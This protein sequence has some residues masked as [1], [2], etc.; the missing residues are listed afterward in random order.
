MPKTKI[1]LKRGRREI[2]CGG[3]THRCGGPTKNSR[4]P[5]RRSE[6]LRRD[7]LVAVAEEAVCDDFFGDAGRQAL[8]PVAAAVR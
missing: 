8:F 2:F 3:P 7:Q 5:R 4:R 1:L 6:Y